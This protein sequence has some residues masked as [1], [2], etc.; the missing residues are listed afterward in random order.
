MNIQSI[1]ISASEALDSGNA[2]AAERLFNLAIQ[3]DENC[4]LAYYNLALMAEESNDL[5]KAKKCLEKALSIKNVDADILTAL[6]TVH[7]KLNH[8]DE[9]EK[10]FLKALEI[11]ESEVS[12]NNL[13]IVHFQHKDYR[14]AKE[15]YKKALEINP[16]YQQARENVA[17]AN[18]YIAML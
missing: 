8:L 14:K 16:D 9:A 10:F 18:F 11:E 2:T 3:K 12:Y 17:L 1:L 13:G 5:E 6:G 4:Y 7:L 15:F